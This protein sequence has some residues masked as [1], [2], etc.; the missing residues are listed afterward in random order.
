MRY[1]KDVKELME[2]LKKDGH[3]T[4]ELAAMLGYKSSSTIGKWIKNNA[5]PVREI[6]EV[7]RIIRGVRH[8]DNATSY[9]G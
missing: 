2:W 8:V 6:T 1:R 5:I 3:S 7:Q 9:E 4:A